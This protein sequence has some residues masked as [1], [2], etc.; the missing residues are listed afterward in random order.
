MMFY[1]HIPKYNSLPILSSSI[2]LTLLSGSE[3]WQ[4]SKDTERDRAQRSKSSERPSTRQQ[5]GRDAEPWDVR[6][7]EQIN[8]RTILHGV[9]AQQA[10]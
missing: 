8:F 9:R 5:L 4:R 3:R 2:N 10:I 6:A 7:E 1:F